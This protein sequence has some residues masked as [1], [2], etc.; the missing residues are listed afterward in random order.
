MT[1][2]MTTKSIYLFEIDELCTPVCDLYLSLSKKNL[3]PLYAY[4][5]V[6]C[7]TQVFCP[8]WHV[9]CDFLMVVNSLIFVEFDPHHIACACQHHGARQ[10]LQRLPFRKR[11]EKLIHGIST[12]ASLFFFFD[13][14]RE[15]HAVK[16]VCA[17]DRP[18]LNGAITE[19]V[20]ALLFYSNV[21]V[22]VYTLM[23]IRCHTRGGWLA[24][25]GKSVRTLSCRLVGLGLFGTGP[26]RPV[27]HTRTCTLEARLCDICRK[28]ERYA[29]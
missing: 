20:V 6:V 3:I 1:L 12:D 15:D 23:G 21:S 28:R 27:H 19:V 4:M 18:S 16:D 22:H 2:L 5:Y 25:D 13:I 7:V 29:G 26:T 17:S 11:Q 8:S 10:V 24:K 14:L 9:H